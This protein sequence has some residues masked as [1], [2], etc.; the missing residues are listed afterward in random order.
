MCSSLVPQDKERK[1]EELKQL[2]N[3]K[4]QEILSKLDQLKALT[5]NTAVG[6]TDDDIRGEFDPAEHDR[7]MQ[8]GVD[9]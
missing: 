1:R 9:M 3:L 4:K 2:K 5:G 6:F 7:M 8:V